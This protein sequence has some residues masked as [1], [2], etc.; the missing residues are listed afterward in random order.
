MIVYP[1]TDKEK[2]IFNALE[3][4]QEWN[5]VQVCLCCD[6]EVVGRLRIDLL[7]LQGYGRDGTYHVKSEI[8]LRR[9]NTAFLVGI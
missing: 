8:V 3:A 9:A 7:A 5:L 1:E 4:A 6:V 2:Q